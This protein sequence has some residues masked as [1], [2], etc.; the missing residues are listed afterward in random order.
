MIIME[1]PLISII[2]VCF[3]SQETIS[4][5][6]NSI[7]NQTYSPIEYIV[8]DGAS[9]DDTIS[10]IQKYERRFA[11]RDIKFIW[12]SE[13]DQGLYDALN[14]G[15]NLSSGQII[16]IINSDDY[17]EANAVK[18]IVEAY[19]SNADI[20]I[21][22]G[23]L[24]VL[25][26]NKELVIYRYNFDYF[27]LN[28]Q[29]GV[30]TSAQHPT[31]FVKKSVYNDIG[32]FDLAFS[33]A[34]DYDFLLRAAKNGVKFL[35]LDQIIANFTKGGLSDRMS[36]YERFEQRYRALFKNG[37]ISEKEYK[38]KKNEIKYSYYKTL[39]SKLI[40]TIFRIKL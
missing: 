3:N 26:D 31:C 40:K 12:V 9:S 32:T 5:T 2:T 15:I 29:S 35:A 17:Y 20:G 30:M 22:Y 14:K 34:A 37:L 19:R 11:E 10:I 1:N 13:P 6:L 16:G 39:K 25:Q 33:I 18:S 24:R 38:K 36:D 23:F 7:L 27:L 4:R 28:M 8:I 21:F